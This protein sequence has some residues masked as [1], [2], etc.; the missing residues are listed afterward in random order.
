MRPILSATATYN[1]NLAKWLEE[2]LK[3]LSINEYTITD[4]FAVADETYPFYAYDEAILVSYDVT[5]LFTNVPLDETINILVNKTFTGDWFI[6]TNGFTL[7]K[8]QLAELLET[9]TTNQLFHFNG[10]LYEQTD[11]VAMGS[12]LSPLIANVFTCHLEGKL[13]RD[14][15]MSHLHKRYVDD[16]LA[17]MP[18]AAAAVVFLTT[19]NNLHSV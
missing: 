9:A 8:D 12:P 4:A 2:K 13:T 11:G 3:P 14:G 17:R 16:T 1:Y 19:L 18:S 6:K 5:A 15:L 7:Q 10:E